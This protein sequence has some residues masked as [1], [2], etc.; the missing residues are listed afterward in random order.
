MPRANSEERPD[1]R[2]M[3]GRVRGPAKGMGAE[4]LGPGCC[5]FHSEKGAGTTRCDPH[6]DRSCAERAHCCMAQ[7][8]EWG[9]E[10]TPAVRWAELTG[11]HQ[12][13]SPQFLA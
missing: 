11:D 13:A 9:K 6:S 4:W 2:E 7:G 5:P 8:G 1:L 12:G 10:W 3:G